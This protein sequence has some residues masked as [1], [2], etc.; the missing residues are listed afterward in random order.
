MNGHLT[1]VLDRL[2]DHYKNAISLR[3][4]I[5]EDF[6]DERI[7]FFLDKREKVLDDINISLVKY[8][9]LKKNRMPGN[10]DE[11]LVL[12]TKMET[13]RELLNDIIEGDRTLSDKIREKMDGIKNELKNLTYSH[14]AVKKYIY[15][16]AM[17]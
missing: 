8:E 2:I 5:E 14:G 13:V 11:E 4:E 12:Q 1:E 15:Q 10:N 16:Q 17:R 7:A 3:R 9:L 6:T